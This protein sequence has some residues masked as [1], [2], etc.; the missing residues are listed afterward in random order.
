MLV[1]A[2]LHEA[3]SASSLERSAS[4][5]STESSSALDVYNEIPLARLAFATD[6][7][8]S[9]EKAD[10]NNDLRRWN[11]QPLTKRHKFLDFHALTFFI[12]YTHY[13]RAYVMYDKF[14]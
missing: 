6:S 1:A 7:I 3:S 10:G 2:R 9:I 11:S 12:P 5:G 13:N 8:M 14:L 4:S